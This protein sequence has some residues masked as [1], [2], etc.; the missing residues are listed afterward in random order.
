MAI[1]QYKR[2]RELGRRAGVNQGM[3]C[4]NI[5]LDGTA[6]V[7]AATGHFNLFVA[8]QKYVLIRVDEIHVTAEASAGGLV[9]NI[10]RFEPGDTGFGTAC[11]ATIDMKA[12]GNEVQTRE[13][14]PADGND[15]DIVRA[16][17]VFNDG[18]TCT[19]SF[20]VAQTELDQVCV[21]AWFLPVGDTFR[22]ITND[23]V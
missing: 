12:A 14:N 4:A 11:T 19:I 1:L 16:E 3:Q 18:D 20:D 13:L 15:T 10:G 17:H 9:M 2:S 6:I 21:T 22:H 8:D 23:S 7:A 5:N